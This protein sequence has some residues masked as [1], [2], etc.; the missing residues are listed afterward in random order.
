MVKLRFEG[1]SPR[2]AAVQLAEGTI[3]L[4]VPSGM[5]EGLFWIPA[6][7]HFFKTLGIVTTDRKISYTDIMYGFCQ[8]W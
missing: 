6:G 3:R 2:Q 1:G 7:E 5:T 8:C 4:A